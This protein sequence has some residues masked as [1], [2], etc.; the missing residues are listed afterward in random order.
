MFRPAVHGSEETLG[1]GLGRTPKFSENHHA[2]ISIHSAWLPS[3]SILH[4]FRSR[5]SNPHLEPLNQ[6]PRGIKAPI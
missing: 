5:S 6:I 3:W 1:S 4:P 2:P